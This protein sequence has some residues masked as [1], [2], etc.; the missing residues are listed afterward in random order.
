MFHFSFKMHI[1]YLLC[2]MKY[3]FV[4]DTSQNIF[5]WNKS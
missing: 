4:E 1:V 3:H 5:A 2:L